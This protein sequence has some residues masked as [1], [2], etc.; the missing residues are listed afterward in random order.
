MMRVVVLAGGSEIA[1]VALVEDFLAAGFEVVVVA[2]VADSVL[3]DAVPARHFHALPWPPEDLEATAD[4]LRHILREAAPNGAGAL[5]VFATEDGGLRLLM[6]QRAALEG[7]AVFS[8]AAALP[9]FGGLDK[10]ELF[11]YLRSGPCADLV[12]AFQVLGDASALEGARELMPQGFV[13]KPALKPHSMQVGVLPAKALCV[14]RPEEL[15]PAR[16]LLQR[17][18]KASPRWILQAWLHTPP[19]GETNVWA[20]RDLAGRVQVM[21]VQ[22][23]RKHPRHGGTGAWVETAGCEGVLRTATQRVL[24]ALDYQGLCELSFLQDDTGRWQLLEINSRAWLQVGLASVAGLPLPALAARA[25]CGQSVDTVAEAT[26]GRSWVNVERALLTVF[27]GEYGNSRWRELRTILRAIASAHSRAIYGSS[28]PGVR[29]R[30][31]RRILLRAFTG[32]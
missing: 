15:A 29:W 22:E 3:R 4:R 13:L 9:D 27:R 14:L 1:A 24:D 8:R 2:L 16:E 18:W 11:E 6:E 17:S 19:Q 21:C 32:T 12:P 10:A 28:L 30:W 25:L 26:P 7:V 20:V 23:R 31:A 5:P